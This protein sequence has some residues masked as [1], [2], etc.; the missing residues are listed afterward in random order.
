MKKLWFKNKRYGWGWT[1]ATREGWLVILVYL[2][3]VLGIAF[4][5]PPESGFFFV[6][7]VAL[8]GALIFICYATGETPEWRWGDKKKK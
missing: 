3:L 6:S 8:T 1:P 5:Y 4:I 7:I 2:V